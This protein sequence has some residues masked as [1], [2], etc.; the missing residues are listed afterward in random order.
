MPRMRG[1][2]SLVRNVA[3]ERMFIIRLCLALVAL[4]G[5]AFF[6]YEVYWTMAVAGALPGTGS[7][8]LRLLGVTLSFPVGLAVLVALALASALL[9]AYVLFLHG[10]D[11]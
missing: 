9:A 4:G 10:P 2:E 3:F 8:S 6:G 7:N 11:N 5:A 1:A